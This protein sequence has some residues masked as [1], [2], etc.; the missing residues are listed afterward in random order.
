[1]SRRGMM[2]SAGVSP[3]IPTLEPYYHF[4]LTENGNDIKQG[5]TPS[6]VGLSVQFSSDGARFQRNNQSFIDYIN[7]LDQSKCITWHCEVMWEVL[8]PGGNGDLIFSNWHSGSG[9]SALQSPS[10]TYWNP[11]FNGFIF[12]STIN[13]S[14][15]ASM[16]QSSITQSIQI[17]KYYKVS[18]IEQNG[19]QRYYLDGLLIGVFNSQLFP[20]SLNHLQISG[21][22]VK[23]N[24]LN[25][26]VRGFKIF[27]RALTEQ[28]IQSL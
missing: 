8:P 6:T 21:N 23:A 14:G 20:R 9:S 22:Y 7:K 19:E 28:E 16:R 10:A 27:D 2:G 25:G 12:A 4:P 5:V 15:A 24:T 1:M 3:P 11:T 13:S 17:G 26:Y 18:I